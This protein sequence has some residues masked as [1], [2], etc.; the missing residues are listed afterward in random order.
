[1]CKKV[2]LF[3]D[4]GLISD[5]LVLPDVISVICRFISWNF[6]VA[7]LL[8]LSWQRSLSQRNQSI[9]LLCKSMDWF[10]YDKDLR[11]ENVKALKVIINIPYSSL[12]CFQ[13][14]NQYC[15][16]SFGSILTH[17]I[18]FACFNLFIYLTFLL[19]API[20]LFCKLFTCAFNSPILFFIVCF[21]NF[22]WVLIV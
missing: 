6:I 19:L 12:N 3:L 16:Q 8:T 1:M 5:G 21:I 13:H 17:V 2:I 15:L 4:A 14:G 11:H 18:P 9:D 20:K 7:N 22:I 10:P